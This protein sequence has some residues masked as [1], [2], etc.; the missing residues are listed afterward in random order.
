MQQRMILKENWLSQMVVGLLRSLLACCPNAVSSG[1][2]IK[3]EW[4]SAILLTSP[5]AE[6][7]G[8]LGLNH[9]DDSRH[10]IISGLYIA[11]VLWTLLQKFRLSHWLQ[12]QYLSQLINE[13]NGI[14]VFLKFLNIDF[15][16]LCK[17]SALKDQREVNRDQLVEKC[18]KTIMKVCYKTTK[19]YP[20]RIQNNLV[21]FKSSLIFKK[22]LGKFNSPRIEI[23]S[24]K[25]LRIQIKYLTK[26]WKSYPSN[27]KIISEIYQKLKP[28]K[29]D[30][31]SE[32]SGDDYNADKMKQICYEFNQYN[33]W[34]AAEEMVCESPQIPQ[35]F[36]EMYEEWLE[37]NVWGYSYM[38]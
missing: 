19:G 28:S 32:N 20:D 13:A 2:D 3:Q 9:P 17:N 35:D 18:L 7:Q 16:D 31:I 6:E 11:K 14:L 22:L 36:P 21:Q 27:M 38:Y 33:Y 23:P 29:V 8:F 1:I 5:S 15:T 26:K 4:Q 12:F 24:L 37:E 25:I 30:W 10:R 34:Q